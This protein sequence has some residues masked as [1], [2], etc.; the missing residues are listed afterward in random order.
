MKE[1]IPCR[2]RSTRMLFFLLFRMLAGGG[3]TILQRYCNRFLFYLIDG[4]GNHLPLSPVFKIMHGGDIFS[5]GVLFFV[6]CATP[7]EGFINSVDHVSVL[8]RTKEFDPYSQMFL[9]M[10][11]S[12]TVYDLHF[13]SL[14]QS[15]LGLASTLKDIMFTLPIIV[16]ITVI[17]SH[18]G[19]S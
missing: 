12:P 7:L 16:H 15:S 13:S 11:A 9:C 2:H 14:G 3:G 4:Y 5:A 6:F 1:E 18:L 19:N 8:P 10:S 17:V